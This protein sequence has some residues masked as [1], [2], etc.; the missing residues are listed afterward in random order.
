METAY[1]LKDGLNE[2]VEYYKEKYAYKEIA[3]TK[4]NI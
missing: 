4:E 3:A 1:S 2:T